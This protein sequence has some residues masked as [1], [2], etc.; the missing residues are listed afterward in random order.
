MIK[1]NNNLYL[2]ST[3]LD[4]FPK[5]IP[6]FIEQCRKIQLI[7]RPASNLGDNHFHVGDRFLEKI[8]FMGCSPYLKISPD[9]DRDM[10]YCSVYI[11]DK[12]LYTAF[13]TSTDNQGPRCPSCR[14]LITNESELW[15][16]WAKGNEN[17]SITCNHC[18]VSTV[19]KNL[20]WRKNAGIV[21]FALRISNIFPKEAI[22]TDLLLNQLEEITG[23]GWKYFY[24]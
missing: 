22:P 10:D 6:F 4:F 21:N 19:I 5:N 2:Y 18:D 9:N 24:A 12:E 7:D 15:K 8:S 1:P 11:P 23:V 17:K 16:D 14:K 3:D 20:D 13:I